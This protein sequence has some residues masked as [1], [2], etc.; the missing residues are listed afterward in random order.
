MIPKSFKEIINNFNRFQ[1][2]CNSEYTYKADLELMNI[3]E[4]VT[5]VIKRNPQSSM[6]TKFQSAQ[7]IKPLIG[8]FKARVYSKFQK[9]K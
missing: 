8:T 5:Q 3:T 1:A 9:R 6:S 7:F 2:T 4:L